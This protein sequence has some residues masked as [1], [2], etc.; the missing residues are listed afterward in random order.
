MGDG[1]EEADFASLLRRRTRGTMS[2]LSDDGEC[3]VYF[4]IHLGND[5]VFGIR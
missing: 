5:D 3:I 2:A 4:I 1:E